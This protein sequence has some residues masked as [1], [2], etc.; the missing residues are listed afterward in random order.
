MQIKEN[1]GILRL[2]ESGAK[3]KVPKRGEIMAFVLLSLMTLEQLQI[4]E[5]NNC[6]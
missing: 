4:S 1:F 3:K 6:W 2:T 5:E